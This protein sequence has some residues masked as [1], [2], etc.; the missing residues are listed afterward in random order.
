MAAVLLFHS[1]LSWAR[2][3]YLGV[4]TFFTLSGFLITTLL[5]R[6]HA[7]TGAI[8]MRA[9]YARRARRLLPALVLTLL[10]VLLF[11]ATI[12]NGPQLRDLRGD[13]IGSLA[14][15]ANWRFALGD[16]SYTDLFGSPSPLLHLWSI[17]IE[18]QFYLLFPPA[19]AYAIARRARRSPGGTDGGVAAPGADPT[20][21]IAAVTA[22]S[23]VAL[24]ASGLAGV[25]HDVIYFGTHTR[26]AELLVGALLAAVAHRGTLAER[27]SHLRWA[28]PLALAAT[29]ALW[30]SVDQDTELLYRGGFAAYALL[31]AVVIAAATTAGNPVNAVLRV[32][33]LR[34]LGR[35]SY[36]VY[37]FHWPIY[38]WLTPE[39]T[40]LGELPLLAA[41][42][43]V[44][45][46]AG[47]ASFHLIEQPIRTRRAL[48]GTQVP[49]TVAA[50]LTLIVAATIAVT[51]NPPVD[52]VQ[53]AID[54]QAELQEALRNH[55]DEAERFF[56]QPNPPGIDALRVATYGDSSALMTGGGLDAWMN[57]PNH[58][59]WW[60][61]DL[62]E[63][64]VVGVTGS[65][66]FGC[67][68]LGSGE[69][70]FRGEEQE[71]GADCDTWRDLWIISA[72]NDAPD[73]AL[74]QL[75]PWEVIDRKLPGD[76]TYRAPGDL[77]FD[78]ELRARIEEATDLFLQ[79]GKVVLWI[80]APH[81]DS[82]TIDGVRPDD[83]FPESDPARIDRFND[84]VREVAAEH[85]NR[86][87]TIDL[88]GYLASL[89]GGEMD[90]TMRPDLIHLSPEAAVEVAAAWLGPEILRT[91]T[92]VTGK[93]VAP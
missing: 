61:E 19:A 38:L 53:V 55:P 18:E 13:I 22:A 48:R 10:G 91:Y 16:S 5:L 39:R 85:P 63:P 52:D 89:P 81:I 82:G 73:V 43:T 75:G 83:Q 78:A 33:P 1:E 25:D 20:A 29:G 68:I 7:E 4:S 26:G 74:I 60:K 41:R 80:L 93:P 70:R 21:A 57:G 24:V 92:S 47:Y 54:R 71:H 65:T 9:F 40:E 8:S 87:G 72:E 88:P 79:R 14:Y 36:G 49:I 31:S 37:L 62:G 45:I 84:L 64:G 86:V 32:E 3:G 42:L 50:A 35:I 56:A 2:G 59:Y 67:S 90:A 46:A 69:V 12:A 76:D 58:E 66:A 77:A 6:E 15:V 51:A 17:A 44:S 34:T 23:V 30:T 28:G 11:G 27:T